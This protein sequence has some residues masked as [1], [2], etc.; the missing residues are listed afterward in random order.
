MIWP[1][2]YESTAAFATQRDVEAASSGM[3]AV[4]DRYLSVVDC[5]TNQA[6]NPAAFSDLH[7]HV[8]G[9]LTAMGETSLMG[10][11]AIAPGR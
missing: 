9:E 6:P 7:R 5:R 11:V 8:N 1:N 3:V 2:A 10:S 4:N